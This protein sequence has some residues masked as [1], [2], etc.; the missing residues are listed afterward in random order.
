MQDAPAS[1]AHAE[2]DG[3]QRQRAGAEQRERLPAAHH[4]TRRMIMLAHDDLQCADERIVDYTPSI[5]I[6]IVVAVRLRMAS[7]S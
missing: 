7:T 2:S 5:A 1:I 3:R 4:P 6:N